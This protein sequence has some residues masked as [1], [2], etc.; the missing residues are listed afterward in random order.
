MDIFENIDLQ[1]C[2]ACRG[3]G[4]IEVENDWCVYATCLDCGCRTAEIEYSNEEE[5]LRGAQISADLWNMGKVVSH[6]PGE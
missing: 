1:D 2:P 4:V 5:L 3:T 6:N